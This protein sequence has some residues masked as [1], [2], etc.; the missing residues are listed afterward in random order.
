M[1]LY[2]PTWKSSSGDVILDSQILVN[3]VWSDQSTASPFNITA[4]FFIDLGSNMYIDSVSV[5]VVVDDSVGFQV[6][7]FNSN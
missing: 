1:A 2:K 7:E 6:G 5:G 3:D 4:W